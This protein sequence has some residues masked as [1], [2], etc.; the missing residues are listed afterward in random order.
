MY[1]HPFQWGSKRTGPDLARVGGRYSDAWHV[2]HLTD[3][4]SVVP[5]S[6]MPHYGFLLDRLDRTRA[7]RGHGHQRDGGCAL[8]RGVDGQAQADFRVQADPMG[9]TAG[10]L[11]RYPKA[12]ADVDGLPAFGDG[13][14]DRLSPGAR[15]ACRLFDL[16]AVASR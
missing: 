12:Q 2:Q 9:D 15:H 10:L 7:D 4:Q 11:E 8:Y 5:V 3:P 1:D 14:A 6:I 16:H 13:C